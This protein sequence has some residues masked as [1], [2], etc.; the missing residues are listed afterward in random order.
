MHHRERDRRRV[1]RRGVDLLQQVVDL[2]LHIDRSDHGTH[3]ATGPRASRRSRNGNVQE[4]V[5]VTGRGW[6]RAAC[7]RR[8]GEL[9]LETGEIQRSRA[10][11]AELV[12]DNPDF[13]HAV[14]GLGRSV[15]AQGNTAAS[16]EYFTKAIELAPEYG[17]AHYALGLAYRDLGDS[18]QA[19]R[20]FKLAETAALRQPLISD[21]LMSDLRALRT[22]ALAHLNRALSL[23]RD[24]RLDESIEENENALE[25]DP[26][27][28]RLT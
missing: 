20:H 12:E 26:D 3:V 17:S 10:H 28:L 18:S 1:C 6:H 24:G 2:Q 4:Q 8:S 15:A 23:D 19:L 25:F 5:R 22:G 9:L 16:V 27:L 7:G 21:L 11:Y 13:A 14:Y